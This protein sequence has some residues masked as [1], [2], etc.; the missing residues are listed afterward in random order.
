[1]QENLALFEEIKKKSLERLKYENMEK[2]PRLLNPKDPFYQK[3]VEYAIA[4]FSYYQCYKCKK[5]YFGGKK[6]CELLLQ[7][8]NQ[9]KEY[10]IINFNFINFYFKV[11]KLLLNLI[12]LSIFLIGFISSI[13]IF[14]NKFFLM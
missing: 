1:M 13:I 11:I 14:L 9:A 6:S 2:D 5:P 7:E 8:E 10:I 12:I 4:I 3:P